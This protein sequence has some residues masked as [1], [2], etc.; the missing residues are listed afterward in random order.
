MENIKETDVI[1]PVCP[2]EMIEE[3]PGRT[4]RNIEHI[5]YPS[6]TVGGLRGANIVF[7][8]GYSADKKY[9]VL[10][11]FHGIFCHEGTMLYDE[12]SRIPEIL[13][14]MADAGE[15][16]E[17]LTVFCNVY[18]SSDPDL[19]PG[20]TLEAL[21]PYITFNDD[22]VNDLMPYIENNYSVLTGPENT[23]LLGF[24]MGGR[25]AMHLGIIR[26]DLFKNIAAA[27][28]TPGLIYGKDWA[29]EH[30]GIYERNDLRPKIEGEKITLFLICKGSKDSV[31]GK[32]PNDYHEALTENGVEHIWYEAPDMEH[33][34][35][36]VQ[37]ALYNLMRLWKQA[38]TK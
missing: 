28:P 7:P 36:I 22:L 16:Q 26:P 5:T 10:Y 9:P 2:Q 35:Q 15:A 30:P 18:A 23:A 27:A 24:S 34:E 38:G 21:E 19:A 13:G 17:V 11:V 25:I 12:D 3:K 6:K 1:K 4:Y 8:A 14:N 31:V 37:S 20:F 29:M 33:G 32:F